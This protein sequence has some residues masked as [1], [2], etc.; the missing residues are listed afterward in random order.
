MELLEF[1]E[2][3]INEYAQEILTGKDRVDDMALG[4]LL[5]Y[6]ALRR[7]LKGTA[8]MQDVGMLDAIND[9]LQQKGIVDDELT[10]Y[11]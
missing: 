5:F 10:F 11:K 1:V 6:Q 9:V 4:E 8:T 2:N 3:K 7:N